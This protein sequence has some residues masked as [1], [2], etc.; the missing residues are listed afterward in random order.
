M[1]NPHDV[2]LPVY[3]VT[4]PPVYL[5]TGVVKHVH[6]SAQSETFTKVTVVMYAMDWFI[7]GSNGIK[8]FKNSLL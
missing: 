3:F 6:D 5:V 7:F 2:V 8:H 1:Y 4:G